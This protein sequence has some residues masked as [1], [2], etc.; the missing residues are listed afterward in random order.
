MHHGLSLY[1]G[2]ACM[3]TFGKFAQGSQQRA[4]RASTQ[5]Y[6]KKILRAA[7]LQKSSMQATPALINKQSPGWLFAAKLRTCLYPATST[8][9]TL[10][11][12]CQLT[13]KGPAHLTT[14]G[15]AGKSMAELTDTQQVCKYPEKG[16]DIVPYCMSSNKDRHHTSHSHPRTSALLL[17]RELTDLVCCVTLS[18]PAQQWQRSHGR[19][20]DARVHSAGGNLWVSNLNPGANYLQMGRQE[21]PLCPAPEA[22]RGPF[23][24]GRG[25]F[26]AT[27]ALQRELKEPA[28]YCPTQ[29]FLS[30]TLLYSEIP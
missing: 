28:A 10:H 3:L 1:R 24:R 15:P 11:H 18:Y 27:Y 29:D 9:V 20:L 2:G 4:A 6:S 26:R 7:A 16:K 13:E 14:L 21:R 12:G 8:G 23:H 25:M 17:R 22:N 30:C 19:V 5:G